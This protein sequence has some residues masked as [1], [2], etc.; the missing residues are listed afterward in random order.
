M[1]LFLGIT[2]SNNNNNNKPV[3]KPGTK[4]TNNHR[5]ATRDADTLSET[6]SVRSESPSVR[7]ITPDTNHWGST[8]AMTGA[9]V[10]LPTSYSNNSNNHLLISPGQRMINNDRQTP[11]PLPPRAVPRPGG[12]NAKPPTPPPP[13]V[14]PQTYKG[15]AGHHGN[16]LVNGSRLLTHGQ[17][18]NQTTGQPT[19]HTVKDNLRPASASTQPLHNGPVIAQRVMHQH[20]LQQGA[21]AGTRGYRNGNQVPSAASNHLGYPTA[22]NVP[23][24]VI[25]SDN[26]VNGV[27]YTAS[28]GQA[29]FMN[30]M[31]TYSDTSPLSSNS[32]SPAP[33]PNPMVQRPLF[34]LPQQ[35]QE[36]QPQPIQAWGAKQPA[37]LTHQVIIY[38]IY[39]II[40]FLK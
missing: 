37:I 11:P 22:T 16:H 5:A 2:F 25:M 34:R 19:P 40:F 27:G 29:L 35:Q 14:P 23:V 8:N 24:N 31:D 28:N 3:L 15:Q 38:L 7:H 32:Q 6:S 33:T 1:F 12:G 21:M 13:P 10:V 39:I 4:Y 17:V 26:Q 36:Q 9:G 18:I 20:P 30:G